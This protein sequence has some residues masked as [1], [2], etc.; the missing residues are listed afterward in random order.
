MAALVAS[1]TF[2]T[3]RVGVPSTLVVSPPDVAYLLATL[4]TALGPAHE[5]TA[6]WSADVNRLALGDVAYAMQTWWANQIGDMARLRLSQS[7]TVRDVTRLHSQEGPL[8]SAWLSVVPGRD[9][10][11]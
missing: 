1:H 5:P 11:D 9:G 6:Q 2:A 4:T 3:S 8:A 7:A 10:Q